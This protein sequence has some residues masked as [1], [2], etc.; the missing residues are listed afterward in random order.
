MAL[1]IGAGLFSAAGSIMNAR[2][3]QKQA[4]A[5]AAEVDR[6]GQINFQRDL[7]DIRFSHGTTEAQTA[8]NGLQMAGSPR[9][10][11]LSNDMHMM[12][13]ATD[14]L[15]QSQHEASQIRKSG[16][17][18][19]RQGYLS[20]GSSLFSAGASIMGSASG[21]SAASQI[22]GVKSFSNPYLNQNH[23]AARRPNFQTFSGIY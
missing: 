7:R 10:V 13:D 11:L 15:Y 4:N 3:Q 18:A 12:T 2:A 14:R 1:Q 8:A 23:P 21:Q 19:R 6:V 20:A 17:A 5:N 9:D 22:G 16:K